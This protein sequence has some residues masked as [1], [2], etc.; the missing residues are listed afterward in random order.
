MV[1]GLWVA[2]SPTLGFFVISKNNVKTLKITDW[3]ND[4]Y[5]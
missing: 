3:M 4:I 1:T 5:S 2:Y